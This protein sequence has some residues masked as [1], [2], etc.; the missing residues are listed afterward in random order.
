MAD[1][2][3]IQP[4]ALAR[5]WA[6]QWGKDARL[7]ELIFSQSRRIVKMDRGV[8]IT[9]TL[10]GHVCANAGVDQSNVEGDD[11]AT[12]LPKDPDAVGRRACGRNWGAAPS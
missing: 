9:E 7:I 1:L 11:F 5:S 3:G 4:S 2:R 8:L 12:L 10:L 6:S